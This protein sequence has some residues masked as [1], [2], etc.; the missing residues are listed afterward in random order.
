MRPHTC[1]THSTPRRPDHQGSRRAGAGGGRQ[2]HRWDS[3]GSL[4]FLGKA[5][6]GF[7]MDGTSSSEPG[8]AP[9]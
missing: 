5:L 6:A 9:C 2:A 4:D 8:P 7:S 3:R 1:P